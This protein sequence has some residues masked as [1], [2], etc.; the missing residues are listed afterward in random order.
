MTNTDKN[1]TI[2]HM[3]TKE[4]VKNL[5]SLARIQ[6]SE[7]EM[8][9]LSLEIDSILGYMGQIEN[10]PMGEEKEAPVLRNVMRDDVVLNTPGSYTKRILENAPMREGEYVKVKKI[11]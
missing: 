10:M 1:D 5:A 6:I 9:S 7:A 11:L 8:E 3:I 4:D 2:Y